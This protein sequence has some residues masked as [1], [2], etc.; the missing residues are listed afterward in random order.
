MRWPRILAL[1]LLAIPAGFVSVFFVAETIGGGLAESFGHLIQ[2][3]P[4]LMLAA[5][6][7]RRPRL[8]G[9]ILVILGSAIAIAYPVWAVS[10]RSLPPLT[11]G[12]VEIF[13]VL[14]VIAG[15]LLLFSMKSPSGN[16]SRP[17]VS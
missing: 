6:S 12:L 11:V 1:I 9:W 13:M 10:A 3:L 14:P 2:L 8:A 17:Q 4:L 16:R 7:W 15:I 5:L